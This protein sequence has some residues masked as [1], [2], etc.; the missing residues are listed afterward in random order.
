MGGVR[1]AGADG[2]AGAV[3]ADPGPSASRVEWGSMRTRGRIMLAIAATLVT[4]EV[5]LQV[6]ALGVALMVPP[7][8]AGDD[9]AVLCVGDSY[10]FGSG[11]TSQQSSYPGDLERRLR[12]R[13]HEVKV[14]NAGY[15]GQHSGDVLIRLPG[16]LRSG[17]RVVCVLVGAND[18]WRRPERVPMP[19]RAAAAA[20]STRGFQLVWRTGRLLALLFRFERGSWQKTGS[21]AA[22]ASAAVDVEDD[23]AAQQAAGFRLMAATGR[24]LTDPRSPHWT[25]T[26]PAV[27]QQAVLECWRLMDA[28]PPRAVERAAALLADRPGDAQL[29]RVMI[30]AASR[31]GQPARAEEALARLQAIAATDASPFV[32]ENLAKALMQAGQAQAALDLALRRV[33]EDPLAVEAWETAQRAAFSLGLREPSMRAMERTID[34]LGSTALGTTAYLARNYARWLQDDEPEVAA[35]IVTAASLLDGS[36]SAARI[37]L[38][39]GSSRIP[40]EHFAVAIAA[41]GSEGPRLRA[42]RTLVDE[43]YSGR[44]SAAWREVLAAHLRDL[45]AVARQHGAAVVLLSYPFHQVGAEAVARTVAAELGVPFVAVRERFDRELQTR[46]RSELFVADGHCNDAGYQIVAE[47]VAEVVAPLLR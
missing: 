18:E 33:A 11:A 20:G 31:G 42:L 43:H 2:D 10:T 1:L 13:G 15:P 22:P 25:P 24:L 34:L 29:L 45:I 26:D 7:G 32:V 40:V 16:Q 3:T 12:Q 9:A 35:R 23:E 41:V 5:V 19:D 47:L 14:A 46:A 6:A 30:E 8:Q 37:F 27:D 38:M 44:D 39:Q 36:V 17:T 21:E 28:D 4:L